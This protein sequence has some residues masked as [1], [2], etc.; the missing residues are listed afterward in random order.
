MEVTEFHKNFA[1]F[2]ANMCDIILYKISMENKLVCEEDLKHFH[3]SLLGNK[4]DAKGCLKVK[5]EVLSHFILH[6]IVSSG[7]T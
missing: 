1:W 4:E 2:C 6:L 3:I 7:F 5:Q